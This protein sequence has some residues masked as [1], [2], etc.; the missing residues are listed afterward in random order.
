[1]AFRG[2]FDYSLDAKNRLTV[3]AKHRA[4]LS[5]GV[6]LSKGIEKCVEL[7][8]PEDYE[9]RMQDALRGLNPLSVNARKL[10]TYFSANAFPSD[11]DSAGRV[12]VPPLL[13]QHAGLGKDVSVVGAEDS[14]QLWDRDAW[15]AYNDS[16]T[17]EINDI[18]AQL[19]QPS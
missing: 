16:L 13:M 15:S 11:L 7:W 10:R 8:R 9:Q 12:M 3:P 19:V 4:A 2:T 17:D 6:V 14:L 18:T 5:G 1:V